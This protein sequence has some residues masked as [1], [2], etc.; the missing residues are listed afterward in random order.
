MTLA[1]FSRFRP[2]LVTLGWLLMPGLALAHGA[3]FKPFGGELR[4]YVFEYSLGEPVARAEVI[5]YP[6]EDSADFQTGET[7]AQ[8]VFA[9]APNRPGTWRL[10]VRDGKGHAIRKYV[11]V[12]AAAG[13][14]ATLP[15]GDTPAHSSGAAIAW[16]LLAVSLLANVVFALAAIQTRSAWRRS[17]N[18]PTVRKG[19]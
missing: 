8:G 10:E 7:D 12:G 16:L 11:N 4:A 5:V 1:L 15:A 13:G 9:F 19:T 6:P 3:H 2:A 18:S 17:S 14:A